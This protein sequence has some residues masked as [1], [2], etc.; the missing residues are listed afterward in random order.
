MDKD[1][2]KNMVVLKNLPSNIVDE[3]IVILKPNV[4]LKSIDKI[5]KK[6][7]SNKDKKQANNINP[8]K[9][10]INEAEMII[11]NYL[12]KIDNDKK[13][14]IKINKNI[15]R[16]YKRLK[17]ISFILGITSFIAFLIK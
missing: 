6:I 4:R 9:Y 14:N 1:N 11:S 3:A 16:K 8:K 12:S 15:E 13:K 10:I 17:V 2:M 5:D 7:K